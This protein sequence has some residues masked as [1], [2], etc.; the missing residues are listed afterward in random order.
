MA[1]CTAAAG[2]KSAT[3]TAAPIRRV[4]GADGEELAA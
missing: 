1:A 3:K 2:T 4:R